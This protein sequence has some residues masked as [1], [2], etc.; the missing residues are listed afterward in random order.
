[1]TATACITGARGGKCGLNNMEYI[2]IRSLENYHPGYRDRELKWAKIYFDI[3]QGDPE[4]ELI[5]DE[6]D[7]WRFV[8]MVILELQAKKA[9]PNVDEYWKKKGFN[10][11]KRPM[12]LTIQMLHNFITVVNEEKKLCGLE[13]TGIRGELVLDKNKIYVDWEESIVTKWNSFCEKY[14][15]LAKVQ[16]ISEERRKH[17]KKRFTRDSFKEFG[18]ILSAIEE[19]PFLFNGNPHSVKHKNWHVSLD[20]LIDND[21]NY[22]KVLE[23]KYKDQKDGTLT[24][25]EG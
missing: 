7:K 21:T 2:H 17:L 13:D 15:N 18:S 1:M 22:L 11:K 19:Q 5:K 25:K 16:E 12:S 14:P 10:I 9:L 20:W 3:V 24:F 23:R 8:A 6:V 4:F